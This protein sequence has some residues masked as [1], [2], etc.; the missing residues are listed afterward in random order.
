MRALRYS[1]DVGALLSDELD[2]D[3]ESGWCYLNSGHAYWRQGDDRNADLACSCSGRLL[4]VTSL[5][6]V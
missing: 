4:E 5:G 1:D 3:G 6:V 2:A